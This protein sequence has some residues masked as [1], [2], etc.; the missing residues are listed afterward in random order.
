MAPLFA[1]RFSIKCRHDSLWFLWGS[2]MGVVRVLL[3]IAV[4]FQHTYGT[5]FDGGFMAV[6]LFFI[7]SGFV[8]SFILVELGS[9]PTVLAFYKNRVLRLFPIYY[10]VAFG[11]LVL[12]LGV[13][14]VLNNPSPFQEVYQSIDVPGFLLLIFSNIFIF[15]QD[16]IMF[17]AVTDGVFHYRCTGASA[18]NAAC[19]TL[20]SAEQ[21]RSTSRDLGFHRNCSGLCNARF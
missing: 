6:Q 17:T 13:P 21:D 12:Y 15:G 19:Q 20:G 14:L 1:I 16:W 4:V 8:I 2:N 18:W 11:S 7:I 9:Y 3:A 10:V 5:Q